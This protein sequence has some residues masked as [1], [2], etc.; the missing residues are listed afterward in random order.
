MGL[1]NIPK[2][3]RCMAEGLNPV[4]GD[5]GATCDA[6]LKSG[7]CPHKRDLK[8]HDPN[9]VGVTGFLGTPCWYRGKYGNYLL[10]L[11]EERPPH[12]FYGDLDSGISID[13]CHEL[14]D[15]MEKFLPEV[16]HKVYTLD[17]FKDVD[18]RTIDDWKYAIWWL[19]WVADNCDGSDTWY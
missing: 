15:W 17:E 1:D 5:F 19:R 4:T 11:I 12:D 3:Y 7:E 8:K 14:A 10:E 9:L 2:I 6:L 18:D 16:I 13:G